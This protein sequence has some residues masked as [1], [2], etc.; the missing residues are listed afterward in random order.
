[1]SL[2]KQRLR[3]KVYFLTPITLFLIFMTIIPL[4][5]LIVVSFTNRSATNPDTEFIG[6]ENYIDIFQ[7]AQFWSSAYVT[8]LIAFVSVLLQVTLGFF[9][10]LSLSFIKRNLWLLRTFL[11]IPMAAAPVA[12]LFNWRYMFNTSTGI[13][14][15]I[16]NTFGFS[17][18]DWLN[19]S[20]TALTAIIIVEVWTWTPFVFVILVGAIAAIPDEIVEAARLDGAT[21]SQLIRKIY[22][23]LIAP[24]ILIA[25]ILRLIDSLKT[26]DSIQILT[27]GGPGYDTTTI[28]YL[29]FLDGIRFL[30]FGEAA[31]MTLILLII[32]IVISRFFYNKLARIQETL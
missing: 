1:M 32:I 21:R 13:L 5:Y 14:N 29:I 10:A 3:A 18:I 12:I 30:R 25:V 19:S 24:F 22:L 15:Y 23:P 26:F 4:L 27:S 9:A 6:F 2:E 16:L 20:S 7:L 31:A 28:N 17:S 8:F 11:L